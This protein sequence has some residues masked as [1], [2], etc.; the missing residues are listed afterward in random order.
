MADYEPTPRT[1][2]R[3]EVPVLDLSVLADPSPPTRLA[4]EL[5]EACLSM[6]FFYVRN[7]GVPREV[8]ET[9]F[10]VN[11][12]YFE[13]PEEERA[14]DRMDERFRSGFMPYGVNQQVGYAPD[15]K[16][17]YDFGIDLPLDDPDVAA[18]L[19][20]HGPNKWP[21]RHPWLRAGAEP[22]FQHTLELGKR[23]LRPFAVSLGMDQN[24]FL[25]Y[26]KKPVVKSRMF[27]Y[28]PHPPVADLYGVAPHTDYGMITLLTQDPIGGLELKT[29]AGEWIGAPWIDDTFIINLGDLFKVW[30]NDIYVSNQHRVVNRLGRERYSIPTFFNLDYHAP[31]HCLPSCVSPENPAKYEQI[32]SGDYLVQ[33]YKAVQK[34]KTP[35]EQGAAKV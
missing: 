28:P 13:L 25:Q 31:V 18:G 1:A 15:V 26:C 9:A 20:L 33:R 34:Y 17:S 27:H 8:V 21:A 32:Y 22:Y 16:E 23:L 2:T 14:Q 7:H 10:A 35:T 5:R 4:A 6:G 24:F 29:R 12:R 30:T 3:S 19:P 11:K